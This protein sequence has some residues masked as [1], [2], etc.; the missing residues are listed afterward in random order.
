MNS[1][2]VCVDEDP[3]VRELEDAYK[4]SAAHNRTVPADMSYFRTYMFNLI[5]MQG[6]QLEELAARLTRDEL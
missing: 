2:L 3:R 4:I 6:R 1:D 5:V